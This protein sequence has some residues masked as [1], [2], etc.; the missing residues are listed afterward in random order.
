MEV[1]HYTELQ[2]WKDEMLRNNTIGFTP[3]ELLQILTTSNL[4]D[5][6]QLIINKLNGI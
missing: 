1:I 3:Q 2:Y 4:D 5:F 6:A